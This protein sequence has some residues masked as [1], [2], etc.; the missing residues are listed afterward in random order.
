MVAL[1]WQ[2]TQTYTS[3]YK[4]PATGYLVVEG[5]ISGNSPT[6]YTLSRT[7]PLPGDST[8]PM[9]T[10]AT[11]R[12]EGSDSS[13][14]P[15]TD[16]GNGVYSDSLILSPNAQYRLRINIPGGE[17]YLSDFAPFKIT[18]PI[19]SIPWTYTDSGVNFSLY[20]HD[21]ANATRYYQWEYQQTWEYYSAEPSYYIYQASTNTVVQRTAAQLVYHCWK[22]A[23]SYDILLGSSAKLA[24]DV[25]YQFLLLNIPLNSQQLAVRYSILVSQYALTQAAYNFLSLMQVNTE[26]LGSIFDVQPSQL[27]GNIHCLSNPNEP[28]IGYISAGT[29][30]QQRTFI[31]RAQVPYWGYYYTCVEPDFKVPND[32]ADLL[33]YY[34]K[35]DDVPINSYGSG[36]YINAY[37]SNS[38]YCIDCTL[39]GGTTQKPSYWP[40]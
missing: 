31:T 27:I 18:P 11:V 6:Q 5:F 15:L 22:N 35:D 14:H 9:V 8:I 21:P 28:V 20:T 29:V 38:E 2:C 13:V 17:S 36:Q 7:I 3:P 1:L 30:Q 23:V 25:I 40:N 33:F 26:S 34:G 37:F 24:Q 32:S 19:D 12:V 4:S 16:Q 10:G 39:Q